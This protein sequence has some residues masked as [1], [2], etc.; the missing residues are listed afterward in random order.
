[1]NGELPDGRSEKERVTV[2]NAQEISG[3]PEFVAP[4]LV[5]IVYLTLTVKEVDLSCPKNR[6]ELGH[7]FFNG[8][9]RSPAP[10]PRNP[11]GWGQHRIDV[12]NLFE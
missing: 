11:A 2:E 4:I 12:S 5:F 10:A 3:C 6:G 9:T 1:L 7:N 8:G